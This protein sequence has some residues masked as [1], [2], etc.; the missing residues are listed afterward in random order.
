MSTTTEEVTAQLVAEVTNL[1]TEH[2]EILDQNELE[3]WPE[4]FA[5]DACY[6]VLSRE[7]VAQGLP[8]P[9]I[10]YYSQGMLKD[11]VTALRDALTYEFVYTRHITSPPRIKLTADKQVHVRSNFSIYQTTERG[12]SRLYAVGAYEDVLTRVDQ[13]L[14]FRNRDV[15]LDTFAVPNNIATPL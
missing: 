9:I 6:R 15:I 3:K 5:H 10:Y 7:N 14:R 12:E 2:A 13:Q 4:L 1:L 8:A 11:R